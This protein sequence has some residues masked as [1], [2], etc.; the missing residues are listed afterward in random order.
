MEKDEIVTWL[1]ETELIFDSLTYL[2][3]LLLE[4]T[5]WWWVHPF[6]KYFMYFLIMSEME[7][8]MKMKMKEDWEEFE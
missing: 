8:A 2:V 4:M 6:P 7:L 3:E 5:E 1:M